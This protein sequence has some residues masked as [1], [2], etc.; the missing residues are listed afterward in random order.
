MQVGL[1]SMCYFHW[2]IKKPPWL[3][4]GQQLR[5]SE[6]TEQDAGR[7][8]QSQADA[9]IPLPEMDA[10]QTHAGKPQP[11]GGIQIIRYELVKM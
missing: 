4:I 2:L 1:L 8:K 9:M 11:R 7:K 3:L 10:G 6:Q 5:Q